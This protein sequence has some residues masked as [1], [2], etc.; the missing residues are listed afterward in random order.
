MIALREGAH[1]FAAC[2]SAHSR[3]RDRPK[4]QRNG[5]TPCQWLCAA[6][7]SRASGDDKWLTNFPLIGRRGGI[8]NFA[9]IRGIGYY[10]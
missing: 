1:G 2:W 3:R 5:A 8:N 6:E 10:L 4:L 9:T 7:Y